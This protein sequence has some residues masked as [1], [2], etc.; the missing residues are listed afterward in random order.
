MQ[1]LWAPVHDRSVYWA[2]FNYYR[3]PEQHP[4]RVMT[5]HDLVY[6]LEGNWRIGQ[7][8]EAFFV[9][10]GDVIALQAGHHHYGVAPCASGSRT[11]FIHFSTAPQ[12]R[13][14]QNGETVNSGLFVSDVVVRCEGT[15]AVKH[16][17]EEVI[18]AFWSDIG[19]KAFCLSVLM[20]HLLMELSG[21]PAPKDN[22][23]DPMIA[24]V[25]KR[26]TH[27]PEHFFTI[28]ELSKGFY[29]SPKTMTSRFRA[30]TG[31]SIHQYQLDL[32][33]K[34][35]AMQ[36]KTE[37]EK[38]LGEL[39]ARFGFYDEFHLSRLFYRKYG[40]SPRVYVKNR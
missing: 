31:W 28:E 30:A 16:L 33:L 27:S 5:Q 29:V 1:N 14:L 13:V 36:L 32:K 15:P 25:L 18:S 20:S 37:P 12:D 21:Q 8:D 4:D 6:M 22:T 17:F 39:A 10:A 40:V 2:N 7:E 26:F 34:M 24:E 11:M 23:G 35:I 3:V 9:N 38:R 19:S